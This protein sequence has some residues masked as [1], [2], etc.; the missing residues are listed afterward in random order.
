MRSGHCIRGV[1]SEELQPTLGKERPEEWCGKEK[2]GQE[3]R[4]PVEREGEKGLG[5]NR[6]WGWY[7]G[8]GIKNKGGIGLRVKMGGIDQGSNS[9]RGQQQRGS[10]DC[11]MELRFR[12]PGVFT[13]QW[14]LRRAIS[15][16]LFFSHLYVNSKE[17]WQPSLQ[18][19][20]NTIRSFGRKHLH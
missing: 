2:A 12:S 1:G 20:W 15:S 6:G 10:F 16:S 18:G 7:R 9:I 17:K 5:C 13:W 3:Q 19:G 14:H 8:C 4:E 11:C